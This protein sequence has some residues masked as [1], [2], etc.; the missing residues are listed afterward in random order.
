MQL[1]QILTDYQ[2]KK[3]FKLNN[4]LVLAPLN[5]QSS[6]F[7]GSVSLNDIVFHQQHAQKVGMDVVGSAYV[8]PAG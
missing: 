1:Q 2:I 7:D 6:L 5:I 3:D 4:R 8:S